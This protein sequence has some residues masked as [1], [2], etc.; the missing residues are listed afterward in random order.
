M[1]GNLKSGPTS[2]D[3]G[4]RKSTDSEKN[5]PANG[6]QL[7]QRFVELLKLGGV[8]YVIG[9]V[10][11][12]VHTASLNAPVVEAFQFQNIIAG[13]PVGVPL[14][15]AIWLWPRLVRP[16][17]AS[18]TR[19]SMHD[20]IVVATC[21]VAG[22]AACYAITRWGA[23]RS[24]STSESV[25]WISAFQF[26]ICACIFALSLREW[27]EADEKPKAII[28]MMCIYSGVIFFVLAYAVFGYPKW[29]QSMGGGHPAQVRLYYKE[30]G[31]SSLLGGGNGT[32]EQAAASDPVYL[33]YR[34][35]SYLL[36]SKV[37]GQPLIQVPMEQVVAVVWIESRSQ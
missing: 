32:G 33:Y 3:P 6:D 9:F 26:L 31:L 36:V 21:V 34:T 22:V 10:V 24:F 14:Y 12:M 37:Q 27:K 13:L 19:M 20:K 15:I 16:I 18:K 5:K 25:L 23:G 17:D 35:A 2:A 11:I 1:S 4:K 7:A 30:H 8:A 29:P 28:E